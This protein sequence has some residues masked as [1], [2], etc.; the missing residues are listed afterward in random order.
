M[1]ADV[2]N[3][4]GPENVRQFDAKWVTKMPTN[5]DAFNAN[6]RNGMSFEEAAA[7]TFTGHMCAKCGLTKVTVDQSKLVGRFGYYTDV[8]PSFSRP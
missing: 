5:L 7:K 1:F 2:M 6:L 8:D 3:H 4:F